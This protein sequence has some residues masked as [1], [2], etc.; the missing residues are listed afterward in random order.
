MKGVPVRILL[1]FLVE[2]C[3]IL[4]TKGDSRLNGCHFKYSIFRQC[5]FCGDLFLC[6]RSI[7]HGNY[8]IRQADRRM[9]KHVSQNTASTL[10]EFQSTHADHHWSHS[11]WQALAHSVLYSLPSTQS[12]VDAAAAAFVHGNSFVVSFVSHGLT[13]GFRISDFSQLGWPRPPLGFCGD[14]C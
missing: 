4:S 11:R 6:Y 8:S 10:K 2:L 14:N 1:L 9:R 5:L 12:S 13:D 3:F 7:G